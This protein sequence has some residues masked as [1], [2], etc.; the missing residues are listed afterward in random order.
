MKVFTILDVKNI[1]PGVLVSKDH[2]RGNCVIIGGG[3]TAGMVMISNEV[4]VASD[5][6]VINVGVERGDQDWLLT[7]EN[8]RTKKECLVVLKYTALTGLRNR[9]GGSA[10]GAADGEPVY[11]RFPGEIIRQGFAYAG[12]IRSEHIIAIVPRLESFSAIH[13]GKVDFYYF[14]GNKIVRQY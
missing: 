5:D 3:R 7:Q 2:N 12:A 11:E 4:E 10:L 13:D 14:D 6:K 9:Y 1:L 8:E